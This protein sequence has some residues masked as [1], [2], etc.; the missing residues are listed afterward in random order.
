LTEGYKN[1]PIGTIPSDWTVRSLD[2]L[3]EIRTG[4]AKNSGAT[5]SNPVLVHYLR[6]ANV[7]DGFLDLSEMSQL[8]VSR[9][10]VRHYA[11][12][13]GDMLM[14]EGGDLDKRGRGTLWNGEFDPCVHQNHVFVVRC[15]A[16]LIPRYLNAWTGATPARRFFLL[17]GRQTTNL[18]SINKTSLGRF[19]IPLPPT[20]TEQEAIAEALGDSDALI[21]SLEQL[22]AKKRK[23]KQGAIQELLAGKK[24][25]QEFEDGAPLKESP[26]GPIPSTWAVE[27]IEEF[28]NIT[29]GGRNTQDRI[30]EG[31]FPFFVRSQYIERINSYTFDGEAILTAGDGVGTGKVFHYIN[32]KF[33]CHQRV[34]CIRNFDRRM[35]GYFFFLYFS[36]HFYGRI[37]KMTAKSSVDSVRRE[38]IADMLVPVPSSGE[39]SAIAAVLSD[40][41]AE[42]AAVEAKLA[43]ARLVKAGMMQE[44]LTGRIRLV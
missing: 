24:R 8:R 22:L 30:D 7:Q 3:A 44:L 31:R 19:P 42:L 37:A 9:E 27:R 11:V 17:A 4:I 13:A 35:S 6:V 38:M 14:N 28:A 15:R 43:K 33:D 25:L 36:R 41:D 2:E 40:M 12:L 16:A 32:G 10:D 18:A 1:T 39:Q 34:Y 20:R 5:V 23:L 26:I 21:E 29:T